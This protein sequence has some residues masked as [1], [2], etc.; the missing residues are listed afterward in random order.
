MSLTVG[1][2]TCALDLTKES[3]RQRLH[4]LLEGADVVVQAFRRRSLQRKGF[5]LEDLL[6]TAKKRNKGI[7]YLD[8]SCYGPDGTYSERPGYQQIADCGKKVKYLPL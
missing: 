7:V 3:D 8:L 1:K 6:D 4:K 2:Y 5:G